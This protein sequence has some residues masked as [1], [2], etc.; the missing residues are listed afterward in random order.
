MQSEPREH[1][2]AAEM[3]AVARVIQWIQKNLPMTAMFPGTQAE[4]EEPSA[5]TNDAPLRRM[6]GDLN[7][8]EVDTTHPAHAADQ[9][10]LCLRAMLHKCHVDDCKK[11]RRQDCVCH[12]D[13]SIPCL[14]CRPPCKKGFDT[15][16]PCTSELVSR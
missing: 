4:Y 16:N 2:D 12:G 13:E 14:K 3:A 11:P 8:D 1:P 5:R 9:R 7:D 10:A 15:N 6:F